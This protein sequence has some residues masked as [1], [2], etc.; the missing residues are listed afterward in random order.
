MEIHSVVACT[1]RGSLMAAASKQA[2]KVQKNKLQRPDFKWVAQVSLLR[3]GCSGRSHSSR[4]RWAGSRCSARRT[5]LAMESNAV[6]SIVTTT[7]NNTTGSCA[8]AW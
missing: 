5:G 8:E 3:P 4:K 7:A 2:W 1:D 6:S